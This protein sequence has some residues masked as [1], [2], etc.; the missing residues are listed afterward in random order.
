MASY[1]VFARYYDA[2]TTNIDYS[3]RAAYFNNLIQ[4]HIGGQ[5]TLLDLACGTG[6]LSV[7]LAKLGHEVI[8]V[9]GSAE[10][11]SVAMQ[12]AYAAETDILFLNQQMTALDLYGDID[13]VVCALDSLNHLPDMKA[14]R[15]T[16]QRVSLFLR[17]GGLFAFDLN[18][19]YKHRAVLADNCYVY[20]TDDVFCVWQNSTQDDTTQITL[21]FFVPGGTGYNR[22]TEHF[23]ERAFD[24]AAVRDAA[25]DSGL[26][27]LAVYDDDSSL[28][29]RDTSERL[30]YL[31]RK[32]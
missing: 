4:K 11:L 16:M 29:P 28:P 13:V 22:Y 14:L 2:L 12:K 5:V 17:P 31:T 7:E 27:V 3:A 30:I 6:S 10:M 1:D 15:R 21:D 23:S 20:E 18:T 9:D 25:A 26:E 8:G 32:V 24:D 19:A